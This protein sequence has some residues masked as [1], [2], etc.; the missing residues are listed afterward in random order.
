MQGSKASKLHNGK[1]KRS[2]GDGRAQIPGPSANSGSR[3]AGSRTVDPRHCGFHLASAPCSHVRS[4]PFL[5]SATTSSKNFPLFFIAALDKGGKVNACKR[6]EGTSGRV[7][8][9]PSGCAHVG[10]VGSQH[11]TFCAAG[12]RSLSEWHEGSQVEERG[13]AVGVR[14][15]RDNAGWQ[16]SPELGVMP[17]AGLGG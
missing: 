1:R 3:G 10:D 5:C 9:T 17:R 13:A 16:L 4:L 7:K 6:S 15:Q 12:R 2:P 11:A 14:T 8:V